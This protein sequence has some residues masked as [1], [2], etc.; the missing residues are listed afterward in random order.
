MTELETAIH[1]RRTKTE[2]VG[3]V[4]DSIIEGTEDD[5]VEEK[6]LEVVF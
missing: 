4:N 3:G 2:D 5:G 6:A 1:E